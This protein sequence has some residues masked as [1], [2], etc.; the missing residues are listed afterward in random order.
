VTYAVFMRRPVIAAPRLMVEWLETAA[1]SRG[2]RFDI[3]LTYPEGAWVGA[4]EPLAYLTGSLMHLSDL[5]TILLQKIGP[6]SVAAHNAYRCVSRCR[7]WRSWR[8]R[9]VTAPAPRCRT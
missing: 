3:E 1:A 5:E 8:W 2:T 7:T 6:A 4:G 9:R